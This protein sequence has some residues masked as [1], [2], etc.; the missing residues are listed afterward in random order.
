MLFLLALSAIQLIAVVHTLKMM[1]GLAAGNKSNRGMIVAT[2]GALLG[3]SVIGIP[4]LGEFA[5]LIAFSSGKPVSWNSEQSALWFLGMGALCA[6]IAFGY[7]ANRQRH[8]PD[9]GFTSI[10]ANVLGVLLSLYFLVVVVDQAMFFG[11]SDG[12]GGMVNWKLVEES[13]AVKDMTCESG[14]IV[15]QSSEADVLS[16]RCPYESSFVLGRYSSK[17]IFPWPSYSEGQSRDLATF[18]R[19]IRRNAVQ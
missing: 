13:G 6:L 8:D 5:R 9:A 10:G 2:V 7:R 12:S 18:M 19:D 15:V 1:R 11:A 14:V 4:A 3:T 17:P 16:F